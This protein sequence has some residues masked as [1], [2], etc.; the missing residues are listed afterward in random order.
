[1]D[2]KQQKKMIKYMDNITFLYE[3]RQRLINITA[4]EV[5]TFENTINT[6]NSFEAA[7]DEILADL[8]ETLREIT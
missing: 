1:M 7:I 3:A 6:I 5:K 4:G 8:N 2:K